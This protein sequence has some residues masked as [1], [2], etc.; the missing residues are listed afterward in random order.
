MVSPMGIV[1]LCIAIKIVGKRVLVQ[2]VEMIGF[3]ESVNGELPVHRVIISCLGI[4]DVTV[5]LP[6]F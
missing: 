5:E 4:R 2:R 1:H 6:G 3:T